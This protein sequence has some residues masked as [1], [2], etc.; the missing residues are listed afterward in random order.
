MALTLV[1][2]LGLTIPAFAEGTVGETVVIDSDGKQWVLS[3]P[4]LGT[5]EIGG[6]DHDT[7]VAWTAI[8]YVVAADTVATAPIT[9]DVVSLVQTSDYEMY[10][11][12]M[13]LGRRWEESYML[14]GPM[15]YNFFDMDDGSKGIWFYALAHDGEMPP[16]EPTTPTAKT[17][18]PTH[19]KVY[20]DGLSVSFDAY[21]I[22][23][24]NYFK[25]RDLA[26]VLSGT[27]TKFDVQWDGDKNAINL[28]SNKPY[29]AVGGEMSQG[30]SVPKEGKISTSA[31]Y[32]DGNEIALTAYTIDGNNYFKLREI[33][34]AFDFDVTWD[35]K[36][37]SIMV[38]T[39]ASYTAD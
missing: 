21:T 5:T 30:D 33:G 26:H 14:S 15:L 3:Q 6:T 8:A 4:I 35:E 23:G 16:Q 25:L 38:E 37:N 29:T 10:Y 22:D 7:G 20:V 2:C 24:N 32:L 39:D 12:S 28:V 11:Q 13:G 9:D 17:A 1:L 18:Q 31:F 34:M 36:N 19:S 27:Q